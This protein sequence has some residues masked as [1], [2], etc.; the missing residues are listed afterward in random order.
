MS[1]DVGTTGQAIDITVSEFQ[2]D[3]ETLSTGIESMEF[4]CNQEEDVTHFQG[5]QDPQERNRGQRTYEASGVIGTRQWVLL[6][7]RFGG[8][9]NLKNKEFTH[10]VNAT[11]ESDPNLYSFT[12][13]KFR[14]LKDAVNLDKMSSKNKF[15]AS[16]LSYNQEAVTQ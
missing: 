4:T 8:W 9:S 3:G 12:F 2:L 7:Q 15:S 14:F 5:I 10:V 11:P 13:F 1:I 16:F 6:C